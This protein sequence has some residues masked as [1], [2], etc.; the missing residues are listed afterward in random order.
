[1]TFLAD[2][3]FGKFIQWTENKIKENPFF[4]QLSGRIPIIA[5]HNSEL[6]QL[7]EEAIKN[8]KTNS[9]V[10]N[11]HDDDIMKS[12]D[13]NIDIISECI[14]L[15]KID[16]PLSNLLIRLKY[17]NNN[18]ENQKQIETF[19]KSL[20]EQIY[21][22]KQNYPTLQNIQMQKE[23]E[24]IKDE[25]R[26]GFSNSDAK[27]QEQ[28][29]VLLKGISD[30]ANLNYNNELSLIES[31][32]K[33]R[34]FVTARE[35]AFSLEEKINKNNKPEEI[36]KLYALIINTYLLEEVEQEGA[37]NYF[38][39]LIA[40]TSDKKKK[41][42]RMILRQLISKDFLNA[43]IELDNV[44]QTSG[45]EEIKS[46]FYENQINLYFMSGNF[47][48]AYDFII[49]NKEHIENYPYLLSLTYI[50]QGNI[51]DA[52]NLLDDNKEFFNNDDFEIQN[53][54]II[55]RTNVL[56]LELR[57]KLTVDIINELKILSIEIKVLITNAG[58]NKIKLSYL[59]SIN[60]LILASI[61]EI[62]AA[63]IEY[64]KSLELDPNNYNTLKNY[65]YL[66]LDNRD[67]MKMYCPR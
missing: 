55:I 12:I 46:I 67:N 34:N 23:L 44:F 18:E 30:Y 63:K 26:T 25:I 33:E 48:A 13:E 4:Q 61:Y 10:A 1:M 27:L 9:I 39:N 36:E 50:H 38:D 19:Y 15:P 28:T 14:I 60:A 5:S 56:L 59:H 40:H 57:K 41:K 17:T 6:N 2:Y 24:N 7:L 54:K 43:Q 42:A 20:Y 49:K 58:D 62:E 51:E 37:L 66:L 16:F 45:D 35:L 64:D 21:N 52:K 8:A 53:I 31:K 32:I 65:P 29:I 22:N 3:I 11:L 47:N